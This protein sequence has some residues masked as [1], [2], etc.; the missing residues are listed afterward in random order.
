MP[1]SGSDAYTEDYEH[2]ELFNQPGLF[3]NGRI[4]RDTVPAGWYCYDLR[5]SDDDP[6]DPTTVEEQVTANHAGTVLLPK[7]LKLNKKDI[8]GTRYRTIGEGLN[9]VDGE[10]TLEEFC[11]EHGLK[12]PD[13]NPKYELIPIPEDEFSRLGSDG[14]ESAPAIGYVRIDFGRN[15]SEFWHTWWP[16]NED[17]F[18]TP[19]FKTEL[20]DFINDL[21]AVGPLRDR[22]AM[23]KFCSQH[24]DGKH[25][26]L[27]GDVYG[28]TAETEHYRFNMR[29]DPRP[30]MYNC[31]LYAYDLDEQRRLAQDTQRDGTTENLLSGSRRLSPD[32]LIIIS[33]EM[34]EMDDH[35]LNFYLETWFNVDEVFGTHVC[36]EE[37]DDY[38]NVYADYDMKRGVM[39][40][41]LT[42]TLWHGDDCNEHRYILNDEE[43]AL[44]LPKLEAYCKEQTGKSLAEYSAERMDEDVQ[45]YNHIMNKGKNQKIKEQYPIGTLVHLNY[46][47]DALRQL[48]PGSKGEVIGHDENG[49]LLMKWKN[50]YTSPLSPDEDFYVIFRP[51]QPAQEEENNGENK[52]ENNIMSGEKKMP[53][54]RCIR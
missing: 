19:A 2:I 46:P 41:A 38:L 32:D 43:K 42:I 23:E 33:G 4:D 36:T 16:K 50:G 30:G 31:Y 1:V 49:L 28:Y 39:C 18:N 8:G 45:E 7:P 48:H 34:M 15:G 37:N 25:N 26:T 53:S 24:M 9:F 12:Y 52:R 47:S 54:E 13:R 5:G 40:D 27:L 29:L 44:L 3:T 11:R 21:R 35:M 22:R 51:I 14:K 6:N 17:K 20:H 10:I